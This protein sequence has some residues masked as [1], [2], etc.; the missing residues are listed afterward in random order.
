MSADDLTQCDDYSRFV[1]HARDHFERVQR[2]IRSVLREH[3][4]YSLRRAGHALTLH[5]R[6]VPLLSSNVVLA[7]SYDRARSLWRWSW[8]ND[9]IP[10][11]HAAILEDVRAVGEARGFAQLTCAS[12]SAREDEAWQMA[13]I[14]VLVLD[15]QGVYRQVEGDVSNFL[16]LL[17]P[18]SFES[19]PP[20]ADGEW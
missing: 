8:A 14:A 6:G 13:S 1:R 11:A 18:L 9:H 19:T 5:V 16:V 15:G 7:G 12:F 3:D 20:P 4:R 17:D 2:R 10:P